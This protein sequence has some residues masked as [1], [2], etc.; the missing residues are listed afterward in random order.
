MRILATH[1]HD[2][3][4]RAKAIL[5]IQLYIEKHG[6]TPKQVSAITG[7]S[8]ADVAQLLGNAIDQFSIERLVRIAKSLD[9]EVSLSF[10]FP[11]QRRAIADS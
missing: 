2:L 11:A 8:E 4:Q 7:M 10:K 6:L 5:Q 3:E 1:P 9:A